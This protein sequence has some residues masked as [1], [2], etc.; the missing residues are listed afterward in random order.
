MKKD[1]FSRRV[2]LMHIIRDLQRIRETLESVYDWRDRE[3]ETLLSAITNILY[4]FNDV[5]L[6]YHKEETK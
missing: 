5:E 4:L 3:K 6:S 2:A 1:L